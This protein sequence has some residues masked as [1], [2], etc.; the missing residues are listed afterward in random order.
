MPLYEQDGSERHQVAWRQ[1]PRPTSGLIQGVYAFLAVAD[2]WDRL[3]AEPG[4]REIAT[5]EFVT[6]REQVRGGYESLRASRELTAA[7]ATFVDA[8]GPTLHRLLAV[9]A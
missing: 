6:L 8:M 9:P 3:R 1:D 2:A 7:G 5:A 4:L